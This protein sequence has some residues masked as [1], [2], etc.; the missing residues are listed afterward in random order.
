MRNPLSLRITQRGPTRIPGEFLSFGSKILSLL[1]YFLALH[2][3]PSWLM[4]CRV[5]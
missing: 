5:L 4:L 1:S 2:L 3:R